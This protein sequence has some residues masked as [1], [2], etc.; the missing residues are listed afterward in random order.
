MFWDLIIKCFHQD[1]RQVFQC[2]AKYHN[3]PVYAFGARNIGRILRSVV[4]RF[5]SLLLLKVI[6]D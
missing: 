4:G 1:P 3:E 6:I 5:I 2:I